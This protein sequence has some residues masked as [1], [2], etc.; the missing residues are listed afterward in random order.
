M[1]QTQFYQ[2]VIAEAKEEGKLKGKLETI[3]GLLNIGLS[4]SQIAQALGLPLETVQKVI[5]ELP[6]TT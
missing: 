6:P 4:A 1:K 5:D 3:P 2:D